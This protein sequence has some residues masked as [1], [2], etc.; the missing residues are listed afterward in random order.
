MS[1]SRRSKYYYGRYCR[2]AKKGS[3]SGKHVRRFHLG[4]ARKK[5]L[6][7][8]RRLLRVTSMNKRF[9]V[10]N[11]DCQHISIALD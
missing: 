11:L 7:Q 3:I 4:E 8:L 5:V 9:V 1:E 2:G 10:Y 6:F